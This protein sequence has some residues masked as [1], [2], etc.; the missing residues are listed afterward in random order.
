MMITRLRSSS[1]QPGFIAADHPGQRGRGPRMLQRAHQRHDVAGVADGRK[2]Q[3]A[4]GLGGSAI[5]HP[6][7]GIVAIRGSGMSTPGIGRLVRVRVQPI[8]GGAMLYDSSRPAMPRRAGWIAAGGR[9]AGR[10]CSTGRTRGGEH[11]LRRRRQLCCVTTVGADSRPCSR[12]TATGAGRGADRCSRNGSCSISCAATACRYPIRSRR[13]IARNVTLTPRPVDG[14]HPGT[15]AL[16]A[17]L[18][19]AKVLSTSWLAIGRC[20]PASCWPAWPRGSERAQILL[21]TLS[22]VWV[23]DFDRARLRKQ[24]LWRMPAWRVLYR[25][26]EKSAGACRAD[27]SRNRTGRRSSMAT[28]RDRCARRRHLA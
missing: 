13:A 2:P 10:C 16:S 26:L 3:Q 4:D 5:N 19:K 6:R 24:G 20:I 21:D 11:D 18:A 8:K 23:I 1:D 14:A 27:I 25:S 15:A 28:C 17:C 9:S 22:Q 12:S 7:G